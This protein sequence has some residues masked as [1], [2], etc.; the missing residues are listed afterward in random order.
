MRWLKLGLLVNYLITSYLPHQVK[1]LQFCKTPSCANR[2]HQE[3][4]SVSD[5]CFSSMFSTH[6]AKKDQSGQP[7]LVY[8]SF[9]IYFQT[10]LYFQFHSSFCNIVKIMTIYLMGS[11]IHS[12]QNGPSVT[13]PPH[14]SLLPV[15]YT[16]ELYTT[17][18]CQR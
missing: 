10:L 5:H 12:L 11:V 2:K 3:M 16:M 14:I 9:S 7:I 13:C 6:L 8:R 17:F 18:D 1:I 15:N 4:E